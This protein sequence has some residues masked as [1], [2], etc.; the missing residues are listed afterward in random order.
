[1]R[2]AV[3]RPFRFCNAPAID[4]P[5]RVPQQLSVESPSI[6]SLE[7]FLPVYLSP[8]PPTPSFRSHER[9]R[10]LSSYERS[11]TCSRSWTAGQGPSN[12]RRRKWRLRLLNKV[13]SLS[14]T[15]AL[16]PPTF[17]LVETTESHSVHVDPVL[18]SST[19]PPRA[20]DPL[21]LPHLRLASPS[22]RTEYVAQRLAQQVQELSDKL[23][24][25]KEDKGSFRSFAYH[26]FALS[27]AVLACFPSRNN[28]SLVNLAN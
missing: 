10:T 16:I 11:N 1:M 28:L 6:F 12:R 5:L 18:P 4:D 7:R 13:R 15:A 19:R 20:I 3:R 23:R 25:E 24:R 22:T 21:I 17:L 26:S 27:S 2:T 9:S 8:K 14:F